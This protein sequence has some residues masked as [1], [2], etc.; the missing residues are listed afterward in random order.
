MWV[1]VTLF[2]AEHIAFIGPFATEEDAKHYS[3]NHENGFMY[4]IRLQTPKEK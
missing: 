3:M 1:V 2:G 4:Y